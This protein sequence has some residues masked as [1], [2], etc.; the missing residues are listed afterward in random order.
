MKMYASRTGTIR[1]VE[2]M[3]QGG[4]GMLYTPYNTTWMEG[5]EGVLDSGGWTA[6]QM[7][8]P[9]DGP[10]F[11][12]AID[13]LGDRV[14]W[15]AAPDIVRGGLESLAFTMSWL[16]HL[17][18]RHR[19]ILVVLQDGMQPKHLIPLVRRYGRAI[20][21]FLGGSTEWKEATM[22]MWGRFARRLGL[23]YHVGRVNTARRLQLANFACADSVDGTSASKFANT[24]PM[25]TWAA[26]QR[27][28]FA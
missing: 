26:Q 17:V 25:L 23:Y 14:A 8:I 1:N 19:R 27:D 3:R 2:L 9:F 22:R 11:E 5:F 4:W 6:D 7:G 10:L 15:V 12:K 18:K 21:L 13:K 16:P 20:G 24:I 28:L